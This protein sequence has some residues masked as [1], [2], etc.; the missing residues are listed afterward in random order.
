MGYG[1][2]QFNKLAYG[3]EETG[4]NRPVNPSLF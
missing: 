4:E 3:Q 1:E 2:M